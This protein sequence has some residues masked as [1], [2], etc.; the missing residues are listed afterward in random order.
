[1]MSGFSALVKVSLKLAAL[2]IVGHIFLIGCSSAEWPSETGYL[3]KA[4]N[5]PS[6]PY[7]EKNRIVAEIKVEQ[8][9]T[10]MFSVSPG[11]VIKIRNGQTLIVFP[12][13][14]LSYMGESPS[15]VKLK[16]FNGDECVL[17]SGITVTV[18][19]YG[20][21]VPVKYIHKKQ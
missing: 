6:T 16:D 3:T 17:P 19:E 21:F 7:E 2:L 8:D 13:A 14:M 10:V 15:T 5:R 12:G 4:K 18:D 1:M 9:G 11:Q 20:Q